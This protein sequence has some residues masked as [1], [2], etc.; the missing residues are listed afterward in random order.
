MT[1]SAS[2]TRATSRRDVDPR[3]RRRQHPPLVA[4]LSTLTAAALTFAVLSVQPAA[5]AATEEH[6]EPTSKT[7]R[8]ISGVHT[9]AVATSLTDGGTLHLGSK[10]DVDDKFGVPFEASDV[11]FHVGDDLKTTLPEGQEFIGDA[12]SSVWIAPEVQQ[13]GS[14][15]PGFSTD[16]VPNGAIDGD[17]TTFRLTDFSG[18]GKMEVWR[19]KLGATTRMWSSTDPAFESFSLRRTHQHANWAFTAAGK[20]EFTVE[21][22]VSVKGI[23]KSAKA[24]YTFYIGETVPVAAKTSVRLTSDQSATAAGATVTFNADV[25]PATAQGAVAFVDVS[26]SDERFLGSAPL[27]NGSA[28]LQTT[29]L[30]L[31]DRKVIA[32]FVPAVTNY[33][34]EA[35]STAVPVRVT[36][37][38]G[39]DV[40]GIRGND[41]AYAPGERIDLRVAGVTAKP[42]QKFLW[43][44]W[45]QN[46]PNSYRTLHD[47]WVSVDHVSLEASP[48]LNNARVQVALLPEGSVAPLDALMKDETTLHVNGMGES[49]GERI[50]ITG[51]ADSYSVGDRA[52]LQ[53]QHRAL[54]NGEQSRWVS[55][56]PAAQVGVEQ[57]QPAKNVTG[58]GPWKIPTFGEGLNTNEYAFQILNSDGRVI[59]QSAPI[60]PRVTARDLTISGAVPVYRVGATLEARANLYPALDGVVYEWGVGEFY[61][62]DGTFEG[63]QSATVQR[64]VELDWNERPLYVEAHDAQTGEELARA[65]APLIVTD[66]APDERHL[67]TGSLNSH[68]DHSHTYDPIRLRAY[69]DPVAATTDTFQWFWILPGEKD[70]SPIPGATGDA[71]DKIRGEQAL[72]GTQ[73]KVAQYDQDGALVAESEPDTIVIFDHGL[74]AP[75]K[76]TVHGAKGTYRAGDAVALQVDVTADVTPA[77]VLTDRQWYVRLPDD[78]EPTPINGATSAKYEFTANRGWDG[79]EITAAVVRGDGTVV[80]GPST[81]ITLHVAAAAPAAPS[82]PSVRATGDSVEVEWKQ[83]ADNGSTITSY[84]A[85][86][87]DVKVR[88]RTQE[89]DRD[90]TSVQ[91]RTLPEGDYRATVS[92]TNAIGT[93]AASPTSDTVSV[94]PRASVP[95]PPEKPRLKANGSTLEVSWKPANAGAKPSSYTVVITSAEGRTAKKVVNADLLTVSFTDQDPGSYTASVIAFDSHGSSSAS[96]QSDAVTIRGE[97]SAPPTPE[98]PAKVVATVNGDIVTVRWAEPSGTGPKPKSYTVQLVRGAVTYA[99]DVDAPASEVSFRGVPAGRYTVRVTAVNAAGGSPIAETVSTVARAASPATDTVGVAQEAEPVAD[100]ELTDATRAG[101]RVPAEVAPGERFVVHVGGHAGKSVRIWLHS[102]PVLL[103]TVAL[104]ADGNATVVLPDSVSTGKHQVVV[105]SPAGELIGWDDTVVAANV[106]PSA[107]GSLAWTGAELSGIALLAL[108]LLATGVIVAVLARRRRRVAMR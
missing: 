28:T 22:S 61:E 84:T 65:E 40:F 77:T 33:Y 107:A 52:T 71:Y 100:G 54:T 45:L 66:A 76:V 12:G 94:R 70:W 21:A 60:M 92:A 87:T 106:A 89:V 53:V 108:V 93:S 43:R 69:P 42:G 80:Y 63:E 58:T 30:P 44:I 47:Y 29:S 64:K 105:Q 74:D 72:N 39:G 20:Y 6:P 36:E 85:T 68:G 95:A 1:I 3:K 4:A 27:T 90:S 78:A 24:S 38:S 102:K 15:W 73:V 11:W 2:T 35:R 62:D 16:S 99:A 50:V 8:V 81:P 98:R 25:T 46:T 32:K 51:L 37:E 88:T 83:P 26:E 9:D 7:Y 75:Q 31:G 13:Y 91:F 18:P 103:A 19:G 48:G 104:D 67:F 56:S 34:D 101:V 10:A 17:T 82:K 59:G 5:A 23:T 14:T 86:L 49:T 57:W 79:A 55:R 96:A 97:E 41:G